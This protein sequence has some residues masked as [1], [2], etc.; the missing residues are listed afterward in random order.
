MRLQS[1]LLGYCQIPE[2]GCT[3]RLEVNPQGAEART[4]PRVWNAGDG[5]CKLLLLAPK[6]SGEEE[7]DEGATGAA[8]ESQ[9]P[10]TRTEEVVPAGAS[11]GV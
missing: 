11:R 9:Q 2:R 10:R 5:R 4:T 8:A 1:V 3:I 6:H 7:G